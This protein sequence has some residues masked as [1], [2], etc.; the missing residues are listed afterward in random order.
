MTLDP[1]FTAGWIVILCA[2]AAWEILALLKAP[3]E[4]NGTL[5]WHV[6]TW[7]KLGSRTHWLGRLALAA[8]LGWLNWHFL[9]PVPVVNGA[10]AS[11]Q[12]GTMFTS[13][14]VKFGMGLV[15]PMVVGVVKA[16]APS[17][18]AKVPSWLQ[19]LLSSVLG[20]LATGGASVVTDAAAT[21]VTIATDAAIGAAG[22]ASGKAVRDSMREVVPET[23]DAAHPWDDGPAIGQG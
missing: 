19:P 12:G 17:L 22:G 5:T 11:P 2:L 3:D 23:P 21:A 7:L 14:L 10:P 13:L 15:M 8:G 6:R 4:P 16:A 9:F 20:A 1:T 18:W